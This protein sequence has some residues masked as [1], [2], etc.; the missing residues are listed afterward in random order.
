MSD[1]SDPSDSSDESPRPRVLYDAWDL[2]TEIIF[3]KRG[4]LRLVFNDQ[5]TYIVCS[6]ALARASAVFDS[7]LYGGYAE[8]KPS[9]GDWVV[10]LPEETRHGLPMLLDIVHG[11]VHQVR[12]DVLKHIRDPNDGDSHLDV[13]DFLCEVAITADKYGLL[14]TLSPWADSWLGQLRP[15]YPWRGAGGWYGEI[16]RAAWVFGDK[17]LLL[18]E[19]DEVLLSIDAG[20][21]EPNDA[22]NDQG[23][24]KQEI[25][26]SDENEDK[27]DVQGPGP[28]IWTF[29]ENGSMPLYEIMEPGHGVLEE[30]GLGKL[31]LHSS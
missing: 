14:H 17:K 5:R 27:S 6:R 25:D 26:G 23:I 16:I 13:G 29:H 31:N 24:A 20:E 18:L 3:D 11:N 22:N 7:M 30:I 8:S 2:P 15:R 4:D 10:H 12:K 28:R 19:L 9:E 21:D 1:S